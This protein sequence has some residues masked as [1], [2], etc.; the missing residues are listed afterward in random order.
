MFSRHLLSA[1][2]LFVDGH[3]SSIKATSFRVDSMTWAPLQ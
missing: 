1:N 2:F 3:V